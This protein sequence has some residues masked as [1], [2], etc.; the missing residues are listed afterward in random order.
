MAENHAEKFNFSRIVPRESQKE[1][2]ENMRARGTDSAK[3]KNH[4]KNEMIQMMITV[5]GAIVG[6]E[7]GKAL[8]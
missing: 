3:E 4:F 2:G 1:D 7:I 8:F 5:V 6:W